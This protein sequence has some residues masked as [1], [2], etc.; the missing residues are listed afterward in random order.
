MTAFFTIEENNSNNKMTATDPI[1]APAIMMIQ[2][3]IDSPV[4]KKVDIP[5]II[6]R[7]TPRLAPEETPKTEG[8]AKGLWNTVCKSKPATEREAPATTAVSE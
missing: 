1:T 5:L 6:S 4:I 8:P 3:V 7:A 2:L